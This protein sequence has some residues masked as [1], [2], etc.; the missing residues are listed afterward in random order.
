MEDP[1]GP[2]ISLPPPSATAKYI[3]TGQPTAGR[4][5]P[6][7]AVVIDARDLA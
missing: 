6:L 5:D 7:V 2:A 1:L 3:V 4:A